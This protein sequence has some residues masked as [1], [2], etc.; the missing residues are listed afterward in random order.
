[1]LLATLLLGVAVV[2]SGA[3]GPSEAAGTRKPHLGILGD[4][5]P[6]E[7]LTSQRSTI[8]HMFLGWSSRKSWPR[9]IEPL[10]PTPML[11]ISAR[12][13]MAPLNIAAVLLP[14]EEA[15]DVVLAN[16]DESIRL[17]RQAGAYARGQAV[18]LSELPEPFN[19]RLGPAA[20]LAFRSSSPMRASGVERWLRNR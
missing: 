12:G 3:A 14:V 19:V 13:K 11:A 18:G 9:I 6:F 8:R 15:E 17:R 5:D 7:R 1:M 4:A 20:A 10:R 2:V 16:A